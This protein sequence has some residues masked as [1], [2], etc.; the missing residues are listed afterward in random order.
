MCDND[1]ICR[2]MQDEMFEVPDDF[3]M[4]EDPL[5]Q[6]EQ[7][8]Q[9]PLPEPSAPEPSQDL[10]L[11]MD[12]DMEVLQPLPSEPGDSMMLAPADSNLLMGTT[13]ETSQHGTKD[14]T[15]VATPGAFTEAEKSEQTGPGEEEV[16]Q[17]LQEEGAE[18]AKIKTGATKQRAGGLKRRMNQMI[19]DE[20]DSLQIRCDI[21]IDHS[22]SPYLHPCLCAVQSR[23]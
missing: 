1:Y 6:Q 7:Q 3:N 12:H 4:L 21:V 13:Q 18:G 11:N 5:E 16:Q 19:I 2:N 23:T 17:K 9:E 22:L 20:L 10:N 15:T 14:A 8:L